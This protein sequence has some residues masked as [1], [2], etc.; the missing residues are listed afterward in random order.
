MAEYYEAPAGEALKAALPA[1]SGV[2][3][4]KVVALT[5]AG[6]AALAGEGTA[7]G[8][9]QRAVLERLADGAHPVA[10]MSEVVKRHVEALCA[11]GLLEEH[12]QRDEARTRLKRERVVSL[13]PGID[14]AVAR[15]A[16]AQSKKKLAVFDAVVAALGVANCAETASVAAAATDAAATAPGA[17][18]DAA[19]AAA[20]ATE[21]MRKRQRATD[22]VAVA[23]AEA[24]RKRRSGSG[25]G[26]G[27]GSGSGDG[28]SGSGAGCG[29]GSGGGSGD[30]SGSGS[31]SGTER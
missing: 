15:A 7:L 1:G 30:R 5:E 23:V 18:A 11:R 14:L 16:L 31:G 13:P 28:C 29:G 4:R 22:A 8:P 21:R 27:S 10:G 12:E 20:A 25:G 17:A 24:G 3:A 26:S 2:A 9:K 6:R 19:A